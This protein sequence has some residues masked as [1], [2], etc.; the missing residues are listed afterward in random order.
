MNASRAHMG[1]NPL[2]Q[3]RRRHRGGRNAEGDGVQH[4]KRVALYAESKDR[5]DNEMSSKREGR[6]VVLD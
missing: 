5:E 1:L 2:A 4:T 3:K 6:K